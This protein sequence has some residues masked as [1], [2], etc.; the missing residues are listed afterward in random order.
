MPF[1]EAKAQQAIKFIE[2]LKHT[3][4]RWAGKRFKLLPWQLDIT[5]KL[6]GTVKE[7]G[8]RQYR[9]CYV[10]VPKKNG[11][12]EFGAAVAL[13]LLIADNEPGAE[14]YS[15][16]VDR[17]QASIVFNVAAQMVR[18]D[19]RLLSRLKIIDS[20]KRMVFHKFASIYAALSADVPTKHGINV[21]GGIHD[22]LHAHVDRRLYDVLT[23]GSSDAREQP[24]NFIIT[25]AG[26]DKNTICGELHDYAKKVRDGVVD[27]PTFLPVIYG[28]E[29]DEDWQ[30]EENWIKVNPSL[31]HIL[32][33]E[34]I[35]KMYTDCIEI[36][37][38]EPNFRR[39]R[40]NQWVNVKSRWLPLDKWDACGG[41]IDIESLRG[42]ICYG[43]L[44]LASTTDL[45]SFCLVFPPIDDDE[46]CIVLWSYW[47]PE[48]NMHDRVKKDKVPYDMWVRQGHIRT[49]N[50]N[51][52]DYDLIRYEI[53]EMADM[54][55]I[56]EIGYDPWNATQLAVQLEGDGHTMVQVRQGFASL[57]NPTKEL[58][59]MILGRK[60]NH[61][62]NPVAKWN[63]NNVVIAQDAAENMKPDKSKAREKI[64]GIVALI[65]GISR[66]MV[67]TDETSVY[68]E[69]GIMTI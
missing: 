61:G 51:V 22:E 24:L 36:P 64:D 18:Q 54:F 10:E 67:H 37:R 35:R 46:R 45:N 50:G 33:I 52:T 62:N 48:D 43:G 23:E 66:A 32:D 29:D 47:L 69:R 4:G 11:K 1:D 13:K 56:K 63:F 49:T 21:H 58:E 65:I 17:E 41:E 26:E 14:V 8:L 39:L 5:K 15:S 19:S 6:F 40:L 3:K 38:R 55:Q 12:S 25:T 27:D 42:R 16:A 20:R 30:D 7:N 9:T 59:G 57:S 2:N 44:D 60:I 68:E 28:L 31:G 34:N 53:N